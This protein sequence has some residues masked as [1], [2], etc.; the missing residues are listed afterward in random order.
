M[1]ELRETDL[2]NLSPLE[3][4]RRV[5]EWQKRLRGDGDKDGGYDTSS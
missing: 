1:A 2:M 4:M 5:D 3:L